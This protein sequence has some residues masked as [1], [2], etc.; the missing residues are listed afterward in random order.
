[1]VGD[2]RI[3]RETIPSGQMVIDRVL[4]GFGRVWLGEKSM[5]VTDRQQAVGKPVGAGARPGVGFARQ[6]S[7]KVRML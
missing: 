2:R 7:R 6:G 5:K 1:M 3:A 4:A